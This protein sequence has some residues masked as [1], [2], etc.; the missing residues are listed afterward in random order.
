MKFWRDLCSANH[1]IWISKHVK[2]YYDC[3]CVS[4]RPEL[5][6]L[7][8]KLRPV[9]WPPPV[10]YLWVCCYF[11]WLLS[12]STPCHYSWNLLLMWQRPLTPGMTAPEWES[13]ITICFPRVH[14]ILLR[15]LL[16]MGSRGLWSDLN[17]CAI[18]VLMELLHSEHLAAHFQSVC[19]IALS[20]SKLLLCSPQ[21][22]PLE[23]GT[24]QGHLFQPIGGVVCLSHRMEGW[25]H[26]VRWYSSCKMP[27][28]VHV[29]IARQHPCVSNV[30]V[31]L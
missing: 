3:N 14:V 18:Y 29:V 26:V 21:D 2:N 6:S 15:G 5:T 12:V 13:V 1:A 28:R 31:E 4:D 7:W 24:H 17:W 22:V 19:T 25:V 20:P 10:V 30:S 11:A 8:V 23:V 16:R 9:F 27:P